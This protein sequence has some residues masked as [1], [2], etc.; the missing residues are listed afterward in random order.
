MSTTTS[1]DLTGTYTIDPTRSRIGFMVR[2]AMV[3]KVR[4]SFNEYTGIGYFDGEDPTR[5]FLQL[6]IQ[7]PSID[8]RN[9]RRDAHLLS[10]AYLDVGE[11]PE[12]RFVSTAVEHIDDAKHRVTGDL[13]IKGVTKP[14][15]VDFEL[16]GRADGK[17]GKD[18]I[19]LNGKGVVNRKQWGVKWN[20]ALEGGGVIV[21]H[22]V[23]LEFEVSATRTSDVA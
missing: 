22:K 21:G 10:N 20:G 9:S 17:F 13:T 16:V 4:G 7:A 3:T 14:V 23:T 18:R 19:T 8:T 12:I 15:A 2:Q 6:S 5:S 1:T 11:Y